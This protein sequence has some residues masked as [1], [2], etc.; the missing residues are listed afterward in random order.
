MFGDGNELSM[1]DKTTRRQLGLKCRERE[2][3]AGRGSLE[4]WFP[5]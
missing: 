3:V 5:I 4:K 2:R 1:F